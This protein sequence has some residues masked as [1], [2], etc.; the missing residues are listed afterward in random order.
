MSFPL[1][2]R[3]IS[4]WEAKRRSTTNP[5]MEWYSGAESGL[6]A[7]SVAEVVAVEDVGAVFATVGEVGAGDD[8][9][10]VGSG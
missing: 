4:S 3:N 6:L 7:S 8:L 10:E 5:L 9:P 1:G 2:R